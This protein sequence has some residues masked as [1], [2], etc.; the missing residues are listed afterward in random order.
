M[1]KYDKAMY[2][3]EIKNTNGILVPEDKLLDSSIDHNR[4]YKDA[5]VLMREYNMWKNNP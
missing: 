1:N 5:Q 4:A 2:D 3:Q